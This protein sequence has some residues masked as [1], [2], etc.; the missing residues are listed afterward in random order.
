MTDAP[1]TK[2][3]AIPPEH[4]GAWI[5]H[6]VPFVAWIF[7]MG[8]LGD[9][10]GWKYATRTFIGLALF[11]ALRPWRFKYPRLNLRNLPSAFA[12]G[13]FVFAFWV[14][15]QTDF[16]ARF[17]TLHRLYLTVGIQMPWS[18]SLPLEQIR[19]APELEG[20][21]FA[22]I[23]LGGSA[24]VIALIEEFFWRGWMYRW[25]QKEDFLSVD[26]G[27]YDRKAF[28]ITA[29]LFA[30]IHN[31]WIVGLLCGLVYGWYYVKTRDIW[32]VG[33]AHVVTNFVLGIYVLWSGKFEFWA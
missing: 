28:W 23:R 32:A 9:P 7:I 24:F 21:A 13:L 16:F 14:F 17:E 25:V 18:L 8:V 22:L 6:V 20:W 2:A 10:A 5:P 4:E 33:I 31:E 1:A 3:P 19:Y 15:P 12:V 11:L 30:S 27:H 29:G 26:P